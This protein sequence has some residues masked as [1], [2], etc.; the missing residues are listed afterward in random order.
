[1]LAI[2]SKLEP[3]PACELRTADGTAFTV[4]LSDLPRVAAMKW[5]VVAKRGQPRVFTTICYRRV[6]LHRFIMGAGLW[7]HR[8]RDPL[9]N[10]RGNLRRC[11]SS[12]NGANRRPC[13]ASGLKGVVFMADKPRTKRWRAIIQHR[14]LGTFATAA[15]AAAA[16]DRAASAMWGEF[17]ALNGLEV[18]G[19]GC[20]VG[21][22]GGAADALRECK[23]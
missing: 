23:T 12:Q 14:H 20:C 7:D 3:G 8:D 15:E 19:A 18:G 9:N 22:A 4:S 17:A 21:G 11:S 13:G 16:Y 5:H 10:E 1:M 2:Y 6:P